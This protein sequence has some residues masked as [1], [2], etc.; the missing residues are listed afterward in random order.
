MSEGRGGWILSKGKRVGRF[1]VKSIGTDYAYLRL[2][3]PRR[4]EFPSL[5]DTIELLVDAS[6]EELGLGVVDPALSFPVA[7]D[8]AASV[9]PAEPDRS[10]LRTDGEGDEEF[11]PLLAPDMRDV[12]V[13]ESKNV[14]HGRFRLRHDFQDTSDNFGDFNRTRLD[15]TG[16]VERIGGSAWSAEWS[17]D[18]SYRSGN[19]MERVP[20]HEDIRLELYRLSFSRRFDDKSTLRF[21]RFIPIALPSI[22]YIDG[23]QGELVM[24]E[25][26]RLGAVAGF[27]PEREHLDVH[28]REPTLV[29]YVS[30]YSQG[31]DEETF[32]SGT[33]GLLA[34]MYEGEMDRVALLWDQTGHYGG[35]DFFASSELDFDV[36]ANETRD[37]IRT[38]RFDASI[39]YPFSGWTPRIGVDHFE[40]PEIEAE[41]DLFDA[42]ILEEADF[43]EDSF[44]RYWIGAR[45]DLGAQWTLDEELSYTFSDWGEGT[46]W[47]VSLS[48]RFGNRG[49]S[50]T[51]SV[52]NLLGEE[53]EGHGGTLAFQIPAK[54]GAILWQPAISV[55][56]VEFDESGE[57]FEYINGSLR[58]HWRFSKQWSGFGGIAYSVSD[59]VHRFLGEAGVSM[60]F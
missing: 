24:S 60:R 48:K 57:E 1:V 55:R 33:I 49:A 53:Q 32:Y 46:R 9:E 3:T 40:R 54:D 19:G 21:G 39:Q 27:K 43:F 25:S 11:T 20:G 15:S 23:G 13:T 44:W 10:T 58:G 8:D 22:G 2:L 37:G 38:S 36:G 14:W 59:D 51:L 16:A 6:P 7:Q 12:G 56:L 18:L 34:S 50:S 29:P 26:L 4:P 28:F 41:R 5:N 31:D 45:H 52:Y 42:I 17:G 30:L 35:F 47:R